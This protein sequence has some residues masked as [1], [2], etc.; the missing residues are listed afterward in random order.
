MLNRLVP[1]VGYRAT[2]TIAG[3]L[4]SNVAFV[5]AALYLYKLTL[6]VVEDERQAWRATALFC[7]NPA[8]VFYSSMYPL[9]WL[10]LGHSLVV[11]SKIIWKLL[12]AKHSLHDIL[13]HVVCY[14]S[15]YSYLCFTKKL[16][17]GLVTYIFLLCSCPVSPSSFPDAFLWWHASLLSTI[18]ERGLCGKPCLM[19]SMFCLDLQAADL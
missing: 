8:S 16:Y 13:Y 19:T 10:I 14:D 3:Y 6:Y 11:V 18:G 7:F 5:Y 4:I 2:L 15:S 1:R 17:V 9:W 12:K